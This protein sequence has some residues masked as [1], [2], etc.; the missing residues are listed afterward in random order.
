MWV[1]DSSEPCGTG[2]CYPPWRPDTSPDVGVDTDSP[3]EE[4]VIAEV[5]ADAGPDIQV[6]VVPD[7]SSD[8]SPP[9]D[10]AT[11]VDDAV[12]D[13]ADT[14]ALCTTTRDCALDYV[15]RDGHCETNVCMSTSDC[16]A[17]HGCPVAGPDAAPQVCAASCSNDDACRTG[18]SCKRFVEGRHCGR[19]GNGVS[20][21]ACA[22][23]AACRGELTC[24][25]WIGG[26]CARA[27]CGDNA[28]CEAGTWCVAEAGIEVCAQSCVS[29]SCR[30]SEGHECVLRPTIGGT[31]RF[32]CLP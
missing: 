12:S 11:E 6:E 1:C 20:G 16:P 13:D 31:D 26:Y 23:S 9:E 15:C 28:D 32:V 30:E 2:S 22:D 14:G 17:D 29:I 10:V 7:A 3:P 25:P 19:R 27:G 21:S 5:V 18:E 8:T 4:D 24:L